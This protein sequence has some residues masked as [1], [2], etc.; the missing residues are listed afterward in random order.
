LPYGERN[1]A[2][3]ASAKIA[4][5]NQSAN[6]A[7]ACCVARTNRIAK[8]MKSASP[9]SN[10]CGELAA[11]DELA[12]DPPPIGDGVE[13][14][15]PMGGSDVDELPGSER[16]SGRFIMAREILRRRSEKRSARDSAAA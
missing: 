12:A 2:A 8:V 11:L 15:P 4:I 16:G 9:S 7:V 10:C 14:D 3:Q 6:F 5:P 1:A 13:I